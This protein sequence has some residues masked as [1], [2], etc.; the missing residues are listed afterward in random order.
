MAANPK[1][2]ILYLFEGQFSH[3]FLPHHNHPGHPE[4]QDIVAALQESVRVV[5]D[6]VGGTLRP[7]KHREREN[8]RRK[9]GIQH[10]RIWNNN[11]TINFIA[12]QTY[13]VRWN[14]D[15]PVPHKR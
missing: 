12:L 1:M 9:P 2:L 4:E 13:A 5:S 6:E 11:G 7:P 10:V 8:P 3:K 15:Q 14:D